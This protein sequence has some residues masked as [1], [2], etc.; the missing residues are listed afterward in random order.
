M[1]YCTKCLTPETRPRVTFDENGVCNACQWAEIK[2]TKIDWDER[3][4]KLVEFCDKYRREDYWDIIVP[5]SGGKDGSYVNWKMKHEFGMHPLAITFVCQMQNECG[6]ANLRRFQQSGFDHIQIT[7]NPQAYAKV[8]KKDFIEMGIPKQPFVMGIS[9]SIV[10]MALALN[11]P[12][13]MWGEEGEAEYGGSMQLAYKYAIDWEYLTKIYHEGRKPADYLAE[14]PAH[15]VLWWQLPSKEEFDK[16]FMTHWSKFEYWDLQVHRDLAMEKCGYQPN[17]VADIGT[18][19]NY[20]Q[21]DDAIHDLHV[22]LMFCKF[23]FGRATADCNNEIRSGR[24]TREEGLEI[25]KEKDGIFPIELLPQHL[26]YFEMT[27]K[28]FWAVIDRWTNKEV[29]KPGDSKER[30]LVLKEEPR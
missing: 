19:C 9:T 2:R 29:L 16:L 18:F 1:Q 22:F 23:G 21:I 13:I 26:D 17:P 24:M 8:A 4:A 28:E 3:R 14:F 5:C 15:D 12:W 11:I 30:P 10:R 7:A 25:I 27:E 6:R 20:C